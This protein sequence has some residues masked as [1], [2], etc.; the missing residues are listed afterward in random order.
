MVKL[1]TKPELN[2]AVFYDYK[3][4][5]YVVGIVDAIGTHKNIISLDLSLDYLKLLGADFDGGVW[6][7]Y[8]GETGPNLRQETLYG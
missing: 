7:G 2:A 4:K 6:I 1:H 5:D 3:G 8:D